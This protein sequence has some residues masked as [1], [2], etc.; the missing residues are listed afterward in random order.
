M[1]LLFT[2]VESSTGLLEFLGAAYP[3]VLQRHRALLSASVAARGGVCFG[4][5][6]D[7]CCFSFDSPTGA[8]E[9]AVASQRALAAERWPGNAVVRVRMA[10]ERLWQQMAKLYPSYDRYQE[11]AGARTIPVVVLNPTD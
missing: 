4:A 1:T 7:A 6:G 3:P 10:G 9:A 8:V 5:E 11:R 2:D